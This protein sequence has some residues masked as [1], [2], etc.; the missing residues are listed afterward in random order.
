[1]NPV[2]CYVVNYRGSYLTALPATVVKESKST[3]TVRTEHGEKTFQ[4]RKEY[5]TNKYDDPRKLNWVQWGFRSEIDERRGDSF[6]KNS[7]T[8][9]TERVET[10]IAQ[11]LKE[12]DTSRRVEKIKAKI[13]SFYSK[14]HDENFMATLAALEEA[15]KNIE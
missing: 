13:E 15:T 14:K 7:L 3:I 5:G 9:D 6:Y 2:E 10:R 12:R 1:M 8:F 11:D 4:K